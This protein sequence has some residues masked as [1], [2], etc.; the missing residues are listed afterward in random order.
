[1]TQKPPKHLQPATKRWWREVVSS[2]ELETHHLKLLQNCCEAWERAEKAREILRAEGVTT[3]NRHGEQVA[4]PAIAIERNAMIVFNRS[5]RELDLDSEV[6]P[7][8]RP[9]ALRSNRTLTAVR[10]GKSVA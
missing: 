6:T 2:Y 8:S 4:H 3:V 5:L 9:P 1:M 10:G 7:E